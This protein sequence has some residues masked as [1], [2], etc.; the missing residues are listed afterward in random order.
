M[1]KIVS[2]VINGRKTVLMYIDDPTSVRPITGFMGLCAV[3]DQKDFAL[4]S[5]YELSRL[6]IIPVTN[7]DSTDPI[8]DFIYGDTYFILKSFATNYYFGIVWPAGPCNNPSILPVDSPNDA[9]IFTCVVPSN[10][11]S[12]PI[13]DSVIQSIFTGKV[14]V[15]FV[16]KGNAGWDGRYLGVC[17]Y[18]PC[19]TLSVGL[20]PQYSQSVLRLLSSDLHKINCCI[21][22]TSI[23][24]CDS[25]PSYDCDPPMKD[26]CTLNKDVKLPECMCLNSKSLIPQCFD[27]DCYENK[28]AYLK[29]KVCDRSHIDCVKIYESVDKSQY[30]NDIKSVC[31]PYENLRN[32]YLE[33]GLYI[34][35]YDLFGVFEDNWQSMLFVVS[36]FV[37]F[38]LYGLTY[39]W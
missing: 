33:K 27:K 2:D 4:T 14:D 18:G 29:D 28:D 23:S 3:D 32:E 10:I 5:N 13:T 22:V 17:G 1:K 21:D 11:L 31:G 34:K 24:K 19:K 6:L 12:K 8:L 39:H 7:Q 9:T 15:R 36:L 25:I 30:T 16:S 38:I 26:W 37:L 35:K 20:L